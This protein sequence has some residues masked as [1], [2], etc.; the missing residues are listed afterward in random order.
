MPITTASRYR[1]CRE[2]ER[3]NGAPVAIRSNLHV[4]LKPL[5]LSFHIGSASDVDL[6]PKHFTAPIRVDTDGD[7]GRS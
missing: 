3:D 6:Q 5:N 2:N 1:D 4:Q 7:D